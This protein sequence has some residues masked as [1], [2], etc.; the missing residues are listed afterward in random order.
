MAWQLSCSA[1]L[2]TLVALAPSFSHAIKRQATLF[3]SAQAA[4]NDAQLPTRDSL[5]SVVKQFVSALRGRDVE[6][7]IRQFSKAGVSF[8]IDADPMPLELIKKGMK[9]DKPLYCLFL[10]TQC[11]R[12]DPSFQKQFSLRDSLVNG[13]THRFQVAISQESQPITGDVRVFVEGNPDRIERG[14]EF[15]HLTYR[16]EDRSWKLVEVQFY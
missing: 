9:K 6:T 12:R 7:L 4:A 16:L 11:L 15:C 2:A 13:K 10:D 1:C 3:V 14:G 5:E 8:G